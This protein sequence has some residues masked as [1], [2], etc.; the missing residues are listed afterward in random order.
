MP[1]FLSKK[2][3]IGFLL[4]GS[5]LLM[6]Q[7]CISIQFGKTKTPDGGVFVSE[8][9]GETWTQKVFVAIVKNKTQTI[10]GAN[11][12]KILF[13]PL[14]SK[15]MYLGTSNAGLYVSTDGAESWKAIL[16]S[17][18]AVQAIGLDPVSA[19]IIYVG[20]GGQIHKTVD[21]GGTWTVVYTQA[22]TGY[23]ISAL[24]IDPLNIRHIYAGASNGALLFSDDSGS[25]WRIINS[26]KY[27]AGGIQELYFHESD[28]SLMFVATPGTGLFRSPDRG[29]TWVEFIPKGIIAQFPG[30]LARG[31]LQLS[32]QSSS[33]M[34]YTSAY[35]IMRTED[36][37]K[38]WTGVPLLTK[39]GEV[40]IT[41]FAANPFDFDQMYYGT[42][43][44]FYKTSNGGREW[45]TR[46]LPTSRQP[47]AL[48][49][50]PNDAAKLWLGATKVEQKKKSPFQPF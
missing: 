33:A 41:S 25:S 48:A 1:N 37:G 32:K 23:T 11:V 42:A 49:I 47:T 38:T 34:L 3:R 50:N 16:T 44:N 12:T 15:L 21:G 4:L 19:Q 31:A 36:G 22:V 2:I 5:L 35:G 13:H 46:S 43:T 30:S 29:L 27:F 7:G 10:G 6:G 14:D 26:N 24:A 40:P 17:S 28:P 39:P 20:I 18:G 9:Q 45:V 8:D